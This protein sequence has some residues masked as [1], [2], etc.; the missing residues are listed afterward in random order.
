MPALPEETASQMIATEGLVA[1]W[2]ASYGP[3]TARVY[4]ATM[5]D[6]AR[7]VAAP[8]RLLE[9]AC[10]ARDLAWPFLTGARFSGA[11][12]RVGW[13]MPR[14]PSRRAGSP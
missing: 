10:V 2:L 8:E 9:A 1:Q 4:G 14:R 5:R 11:A 7:T 12:L 6:F 13:A 3:E